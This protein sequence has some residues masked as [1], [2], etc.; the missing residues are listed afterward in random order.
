MCRVVSRP[1]TCGNG[2]L[3]TLTY[4]FYTLSDRL[5][6]IVRHKITHALEANDSLCNFL[7][8]AHFTSPSLVLISDFL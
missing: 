2:K 4:G 1:C 8:G 3:Y 6:L 7:V 5:P